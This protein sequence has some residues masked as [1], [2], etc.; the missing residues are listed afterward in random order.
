MNVGNVRN[1]HQ[2]MENCINV[3]YVKENSKETI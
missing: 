1:Y 3:Q 2:N